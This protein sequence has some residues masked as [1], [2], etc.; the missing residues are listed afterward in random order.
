MS[1]N[2]KTCYLLIQPIFI[3]DLLYTR[4]CPRNGKHLLNGNNTRFCVDPS[5][6]MPRS[7]QL[8]V[9]RRHTGLRAQA[10]YNRILSCMFPSCSS[11][12]DGGDF[13][14]TGIH[15]ARTLLCC[16]AWGPSKMTPGTANVQYLPLPLYLVWESV[17]FLRRNVL[18]HVRTS[19]TIA[20]RSCGPYK[21]K[22]KL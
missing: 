3:N 21:S 11:K 6:Q 10:F 19:D 7:F 17:P 20:I 1:G 8:W 5:L 14:S 16:H 18:S 15:R 2:R 22:T 4:T 12:A 9:A 13:L